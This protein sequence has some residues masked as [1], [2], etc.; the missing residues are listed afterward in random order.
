MLDD[1]VAWTIVAESVIQASLRRAESRGCFYRSDHP[2]AVQRMKTYFSCTSYD[3]EADVVTSRL[4]RIAD[5]SS[6]L[7]NNSDGTEY[8]AAVS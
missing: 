8:R 4:I 1:A 3:R 5:L 7:S 6:V 2:M